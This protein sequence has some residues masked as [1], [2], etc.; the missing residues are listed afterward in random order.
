MAAS[1]RGRGHDL[2]DRSPGAPRS[3]NAL[4]AGA[5]LL[6]GSA[7]RNLIC[8]SCIQTSSDGACDH[9]WIGGILSYAGALCPGR[10]RANWPRQPCQDRTDTAGSSSASL[11]PGAGRGRRM[12]QRMQRM[13][14]SRRAFRRRIAATAARV[15][16]PSFRAQAADFLFVARR[17]CD[18]SLGNRTAHARTRHD[19]RRGENRSARLCASPG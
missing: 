12:R 6:R 18:S 13:D 10:G 2:D 14:R 17:V 4:G 19:G 5:D 8:C 7:R 3:V 9:S 15:S 16:Q 11:L 1:Y